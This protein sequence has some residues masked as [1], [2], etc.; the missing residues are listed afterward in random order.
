MSC[1]Q[2]LILAIVVL[3]STFDVVSSVLGTSKLLVSNGTRKRGKQVDRHWTLYRIRQVTGT[4]NITS[5][6]IAISAGNK[7][8]IA[9]GGILNRFVKNVSSSDADVI[10]VAKIAVEYG[11]RRFPWAFAD[12][13]YTLSRLRK[14]R[15][16]YTANDEKPALYRTVDPNSGHLTQTH[17]MWG[18]IYSFQVSWPSQ[19]SSYVH[20]FCLTEY[21]DNEIYIYEHTFYRNISSHDACTCPLAWCVLLACAVLP[22]CG[23]PFAQGHPCAGAIYTPDVCTQQRTSKNL[24]I[25]TFNLWN[26]NS[27][28]NTHSAYTKRIQR[29]A[30][31]CKES[32]ADVI[33]IQ[34]VRFQ[35]GSGQ[36]LGPNQVQHLATLL[37]EYQFTFRP[38]QIQ[39]TNLPSR[40]EEG[41]AIFSK[42]P[43]T[44]TTAILLSRNKRDPGDGHQ[45]LLLHCAVDIPGVGQVHLLNTHLSL[46]HLAR[47]NSVIEI[48]RKISSIN[49]N[50]PVFLMGDFN[51]EGHNTEIKFLS[52]KVPLNGVKTRGFLDVW[53]EVHGPQET[54][55]G[56][57]FSTLDDQ[58]TKRIDFIYTRESS[59]VSIERVKLLDDHNRKSEVAS[60]HVGLLAEFTIK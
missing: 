22:S 15:L 13:D 31:L 54:S 24:K 18:F 46:S 38:A 32:R 34:E 37:P 10:R 25:L 27:V 49:S 21:W 14:L 50:E 29:F 51:A 2:Q 57:T 3:G 52:G 53:E 58:L 48:W 36:H 20:K 5:V 39:S 28:E 1:I 9:Y 43:I 41:L 23:D 45:R 59:R 6:R 33:G 47:Q 4:R 11:N 26:V 16:Q 35:D 60:D 30:Q 19:D 42:Y 44:N 56:F 55:K 8:K 17:L 7:R 40:A 12:S